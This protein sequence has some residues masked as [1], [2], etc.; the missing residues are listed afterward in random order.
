[1]KHT[2]TFEVMGKKYRTRVEA[3]SKTEAENKLKQKIMQS[4]KIL[5]HTQGAD[6]D[7]IMNQFKNIF[8]MK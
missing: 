8:G 3:G 4:F 7:D 1:M 2:I 5:E 6:L